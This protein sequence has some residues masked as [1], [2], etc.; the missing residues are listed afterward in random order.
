[1]KEY[2]ANMKNYTMRNKLECNYDSMKHSNRLT[3]SRTTHLFL[4][5]ATAFLKH[6]N[7]EIPFVYL[8]VKELQTQKLIQ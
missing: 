1:M 3:S 7:D 5:I 8:T 2:G 6:L 4:L